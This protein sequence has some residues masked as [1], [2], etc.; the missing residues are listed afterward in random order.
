MAQYFQRRII[1][2]RT[3]HVAIGIV[4]IW[5]EELKKDEEE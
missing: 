4:E 1:N 3:D 2:E 5:S